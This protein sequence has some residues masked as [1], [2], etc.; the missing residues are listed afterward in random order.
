MIKRSIV[1]TLVFLA[2]FANSAFAL[3]ETK[4]FKVK[5]NCEQCKNRIEKLVL[6]ENGVFEAKWDM[7]SKIMTVTFENTITSIYRLQTIL[8]EKGHDTEFKKAT[9]KSYNTLPQCC[10]YD[11]EIV[12]RCCH[13]E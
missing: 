10:K 5:G 8:A 9:Q 3:K 4:H 6:D 13:Q 11:R 1:L 7:E 12:K 2:I